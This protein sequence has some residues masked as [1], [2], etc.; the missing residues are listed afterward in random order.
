MLLL[1]GNYTVTASRVLQRREKERHRKVQIK[2][3]NIKY[4]PTINIYIMYKMIR[5]LLL[6]L[7]C[8]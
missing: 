6:I 1:S 2:R 3:K 7:N 4:K 5:T 8:T